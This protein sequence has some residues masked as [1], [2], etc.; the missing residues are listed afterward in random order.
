MSYIPISSCGSTLYL[1]PYRSFWPQKNVKYLPLVFCHRGNFELD[2][3]ES[4]SCYRNVLDKVAVIHKH[5]YCLHLKWITCREVWAV[6][7]T[8]PP[9][10]TFSN[11]EQKKQSASTT[12][13]LTDSFKLQYTFYMQGHVG[14][15]S[16]TEWLVVE[17]LYREGTS[18]CWMKWTEFGALFIL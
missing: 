16:D 7:V 5:I 12:I 11:S 17:R 10:Q 14:D 8:A 13:N 3:W 1:P 2:L 15:Q 9:I 6:R 4:L 18:V